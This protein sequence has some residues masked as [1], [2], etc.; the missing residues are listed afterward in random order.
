MS[1]AGAPIAQHHSDPAAIP[2]P[3]APWGEIA[4]FA[5]T[6]GVDRGFDGVG[7]EDLRSFAHERLQRFEATGEVPEAADDVERCLYGLQRIHHW[8]DS[9]PGEEALV[10]IHRLVEALRA[11]GTGNATQGSS[12]AITPLPTLMDL[13][14][15]FAGYRDARLKL[16]AALGAPA[17]KASNRDP[18]AEFSEVLSAVVHSGRL[19]DVRTQKGFDVIA[20]SGERVQVKYLANAAPTWVN[21]HLVQVIPDVHRY[22]L[23]VFEDLQPVALLSFPLTNLAAIAADLRKRHADTHLMIQI[24]QANVS[25]IL[26]S[27]AVFESRGMLIRRLSVAPEALH[28]M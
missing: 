5:C 22:D 12:A 8:L 6:R 3:D 19:A 20:A 23:V 25:A 15:A 9:P 4:T 14:S 24:T 10:F 18:L 7:S 16:L 11:A 21:G 1:D 13:L 17:M 2:G 27:P 28:Q 26:N